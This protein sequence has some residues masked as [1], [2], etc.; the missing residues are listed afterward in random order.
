MP[1]EHYLF[2]IFDVAGEP[3]LSTTNSI[4]Y[5][6]FIHHFQEGKTFSYCAKAARLFI[7]TK[8][9]SAQLKKKETFMLCL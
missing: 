4:K 7:I 6:I 1:E 3:L 9:F 2:N 8:T 5:A